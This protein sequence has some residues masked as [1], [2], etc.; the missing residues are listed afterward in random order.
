MSISNSAN[1]NELEKPPISTGNPVGAHGLWTHS[2]P[3]I[4]S[5][6]IV[7]TTTRLS[8]ARGSPLAVLGRRLIF[9][10]ACLRKE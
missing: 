2:S 1:R 10:C 8:A 4:V 6:T 3:W 7:Y 5:S 9:Y